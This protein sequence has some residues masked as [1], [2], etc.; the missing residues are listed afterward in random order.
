MKNPLRIISIVLGVACLLSGIYWIY[1]GSE[2]MEIIPPIILGAGL[3]GLT[4]LGPKKGNSKK[5]K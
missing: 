5:I 1:K 3:I 4:Y 2:L